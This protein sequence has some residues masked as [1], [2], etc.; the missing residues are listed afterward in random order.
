MTRVFWIALFSCIAACV[1][2]VAHADAIPTCPTTTIT[3]INHRT[4]TARVCVDAPAELWSL[5]PGYF[6]RSFPEAGCFVHPRPGS[7]VDVNDQICVGHEYALVFGSERT[8]CR[9]RPTFVVYLPV[10]LR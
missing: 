10:L 4:G 5:T 3:F 2:P 1:H 6:L 7:P 8:G 9:A